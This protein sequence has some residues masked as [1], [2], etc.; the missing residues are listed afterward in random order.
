VAFADG[1]GA[2]LSLD[3]VDRLR[4]GVGGVLDD[5]VAEEIAREET[6]LAAYDR[7]V[8]MLALRGRSSQELRRRLVQKGED[9]PVVDIVIERLTHAGFL[10]DASFARQFARSKALGAGLSRRRLKQELSRKGI[11]GSVSEEAIADVFSEEAID[12][13]AAIERVAR[14]KLKS[15]AQLDE[16]TQRRR[17]FAFLARRGY[18]SSDIARVVRA[19]VRAPNGDDFVET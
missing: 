12:E 6:I 17:L 13:D 8:N 10:D 9:A 18:D 1:A 15:L 11:A 5:R 4:L 7:A 19:L 3:A 14:K 2:T 16:A